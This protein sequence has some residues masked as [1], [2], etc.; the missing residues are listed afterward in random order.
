MESTG[1]IIERQ[2]CH[3]EFY[4]S[5]LIILCCTITLFLFESF[6]KEGLHFYL[7]FSFSCIFYTMLCSTAVIVVMVFQ[8]I[9]YICVT[10]EICIFFMVNYLNK[11]GKLVYFIYCLLQLCI[12]IG[13]FIVPYSRHKK[14]TDVTFCLTK[15]LHLPFYVKTK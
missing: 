14:L 13:S 1:Y 12:Y 6:S 4:E 3:T 15:A 11:S 7:P 5:V 2:L 10:F 9:N 8:L